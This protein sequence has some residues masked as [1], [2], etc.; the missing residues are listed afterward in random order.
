MTTN[1][2]VAPT[3]PSK[4]AV[5]VRIC[6]LV[7]GV[8]FVVAALA[9]ISDLPAFARQ[10]HNF[11]LIPLWSEHLFAMTAPW[12]E[13]VAGLAL[14]LGIRARAGA[15]V[16]T[17]SL[18]VFTVAVGLAMARHLDIECG[19]FGTADASRVGFVKLLENIGML[20]VASIASWRTR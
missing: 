17:A 2:S 5:L 8:L 18:V 6:Q 1:I 13:L 20:I 4:R 3:A 16:V 11:H 7:I 9:K 14:V 15:V 10:L 12:I 19:C